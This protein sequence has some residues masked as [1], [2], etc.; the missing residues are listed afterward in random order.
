MY[1]ENI[2]L[3]AQELL[4]EGGNKCIKTMKG[5]NF[6]HKYQYKLNQLH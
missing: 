2:W 3:N 1:K 5:L 6:F 4:L